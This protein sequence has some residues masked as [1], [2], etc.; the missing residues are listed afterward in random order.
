[1]A[2]SKSGLSPV[3]MG[4][5]PNW[6]SILVNKHLQKC[7]HSN[8]NIRDGTNSS[9]QPVPHAQAVPT[10]LWVTISPPKQF[11]SKSSVA[12]VLLF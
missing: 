6:R 1:M 12:S 3:A 7:F 10:L 11:V 4:T 9:N 5:K 8:P 2:G